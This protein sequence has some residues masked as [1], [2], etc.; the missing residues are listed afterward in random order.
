MK[1]TEMLSRV[2]T[3]SLALALAFS[4]SAAPS[5][6]QVTSTTTV[7]S[8]QTVQPVTVTR[9]QYPATVTTISPDT[10]TLDVNGSAVTLPA[11]FATYS[12]NG[13]IINPSTLQT[14]QRVIV[15]YPD[16]NGTVA[17]LNGNMVLIQN[18]DG[19]TVMVPMT[20]LNPSLRSD[21]VYVRLSNGNYAMVP[22]SSAINLQNHEGATIV[23]TLPPGVV[24]TPY[25]A[26]ATG[27][28]SGMNRDINWSQGVLIQKDYSKL[29]QDESIEGDSNF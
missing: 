16:F 14:G 25:Y 21:L 1:L 18:A 5:H 13:S 7:T 19:S 8:S 15:M 3:G 11:Q 17:G 27:V 9:I 28:E 12:Y 4:L 6:A 26:S 24:V 20:A 22:L 10:V 2:V 29:I 23:S